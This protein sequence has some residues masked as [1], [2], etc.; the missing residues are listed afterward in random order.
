MMR[1]HSR[2]YSHIGPALLM[3]SNIPLFGLEQ[4]LRELVLVWFVVV[5]GV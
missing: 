5:A 3:N 2:P 4:G 1:L